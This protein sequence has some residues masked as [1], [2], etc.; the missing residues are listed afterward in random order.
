MA[1]K[2]ISNQPDLEVDPGQLGNLNR[3]QFLALCVALG[4]TPLLGGRDACGATK[5]IIIA[6]WGGDTGKAII[7]AFLEPFSA[8]TGINAI[9]DG[10]GTPE[11]KIR[12]MVESKRVTWDVIDTGVGTIITLAKDGY[13][14]EIDYSIV[15]KAKVPPGFAYKYGIAN[16]LFSYVLAYDKTKFGGKAPNSWADFWNL[17]D[18]PGRRAIRKDIQG[19]LEIALMADG[20]PLD[21][22]YPID[23]ERAFAKLRE[24]KKDTIF[25]SSGSESQQL[26]REGEVTMAELWSTRVTA[27]AR[28]TNDRISW[29]WN[30]GILC[31]GVWAV[32]KGNPGGKDAF[33][34][35]AFAQDP[36][37]Q[38]ELFKMIRGGPAN[39]A[40]AKL[41]PADLAR[42]DPGY[43]DNAKTQLKVNAE[44]YGENQTR[45]TDKLLDFVAS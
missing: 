38:L 35:I 33:R 32:P 22:I 1:R 45:L 8:E 44:W 23:E 42:F 25:W 9:N 41:M 40:T 7:K 26:L 27:L 5:E 29:T 28:D 18:F 34:F 20:V 31:P 2:E 13:L 30:Q 36:Q 6:N 15:D 16:Y 21:K 19:T 43:P 11:G 37:R 14:E 10:S 17:K 3:R 12:A 39:P 24:I 4:A